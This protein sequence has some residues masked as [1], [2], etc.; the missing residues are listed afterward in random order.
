MQWKDMTAQE[1][2]K[3]V[4]MARSGQKPIKE[5]CRTFGVSRQTLSKAIERASQAALAA[6]E[7]KRPGRKARSEQEQEVLGLLEKTGTLEKQVKDWKTRYEVALAFIDLSREQEQ[8]ERKKG[9]KKKRP[10]PSRKFSTARQSALLAPD[11]HGQ[12]AGPETAKP[13]EVD[14]KS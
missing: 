6:L 2:L 11:G 5:I 4:E 14:E 1:R 10:K 3:V 8:Q 12:G 13:G 7:P 9:K